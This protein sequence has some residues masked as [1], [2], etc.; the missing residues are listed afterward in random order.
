MQSM[1]RG[2]SRR[3]WLLQSASALVVGAL[4]GGA[5]AQTPSPPPGMKAI[6]VAGLREHATYLASDELGGRYTGS[7]GQVA[8]AEY[9]AARFAEL[10]LQPLG[11]KGRSGR[12]FFQEY[13]VERESLDPKKTW[14]SI[15]GEKIASGFAVIRGKKAGVTA[16]KGAIAFCGDGSPDEIPRGNL[17]RA[18]PL[19]L[20][21]DPTDDGPMG[22]MRA[23]RVLQRA[24]QISRELAGRGAR[25]VLFGLLRTG[26]VADSLNATALLPDKPLLRFGNEAGRHAQPHAVPSVFLGR[27]LAVRM[28]SQLG[29]D[30]D[31]TEVVAPA[32]PRKVS[33]SVSVGVR[34]EP[35]A[36]ARNVVAWLAGGRASKEAV[37]YSAHMDHMGTRLDGDAFNGADDN[38]SGT[39][40]LLE[41]AE[42]FA[43]SEPPER[44]IVFLSVSGEELGLWGSAYFTEHPTWPLKRI[45][46][47]I[48]I[49]MI[50]RNAADSIEVTPS[51]AHADYSTLVRTAVE[52]GARLGI[53]FV[54]GDKYYKRSDHYNFAQRGIPVVFFCDGEHEDYH[55]VSDHAELLDYDK[56]ARVAQLAYWT[57]W[58]VAQARGRPRALGSQ[59]SW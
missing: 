46:A 20:L 18:V 27:P 5:W 14:V 8:A 47:N 21:D 15:D 54:S 45:V 53:G 24:G 19:V 44:S 39:A 16:A 30:V 35:R 13:P 56:M 10:G 36:T 9:V 51:H 22:A 6:D 43:A 25:L 2:A 41:I 4:G 38:A 7:A 42:A 34:H 17:R 49:D 11:D 50:G 31:D 29:F 37:V 40:G 58:E 57:G 33:A 55:K 32:T 26:G 3:R 12:S 28:L 48:N 52:L 1:K 59:P 23:V